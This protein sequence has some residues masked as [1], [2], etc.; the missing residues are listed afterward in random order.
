MGNKAGKAC[1][2]LR[3]DVPVPVLTCA[4]P[5]GAQP[6]QQESLE[7]LNK[8]LATMWPKVDEAIQKIVHDQVT[9]QLQ[10]KLPGPLK[11]THFKKF[12]LGSVTPRLGPIEVVK[13]ETGL[14]LILGMDYES[15]ADIEIS[16]VVATIGIKAIK[17]KGNLVIRMAPFMDDL[18]VVGGLT[19]YFVDPPELD[20]SFTGIGKIGQCPGIA[21][22]IRNEIHAVLG[23]TAVLPNSIAVP[24]GTPEQGVDPCLLKLPMPIAVLRVTALRAVKLTAKDWHLMSKASSDPFVKVHIANDIWQSSVRKRTCDPEWGIEDTHD[25]MVFDRDQ[26][27]FVDVLDMEMLGSTDLIG[28]V[29]P[30]KVIDA[31]ARSEKPLPLVDPKHVSQACGNLEMKF[32]WLKLVPLQKNSESCI[33][34]VKILNL[35]LPPGLGEA[36]G[37]TGTLGSQQLATPVATAQ[38]Q[39][40][41][42]TTAVGQA[43]A[44]V[45][46]RCKAKGLDVDAIAEITGLSKDG[47][48]AA[49]NSEGDASNIASSHSKVV[50]ELDGLLYFPVPRKELETQEL[51]ISAVNAQNKPFAETAINMLDLLASEA[52]RLPGP[53]QLCV[54]KGHGQHVEAQIEVSI[55][56]LQ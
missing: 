51:M 17:F 54:G 23:N 24:I 32:E 21:G 2:A 53:F 42:T 33:V 6:S 25:F 14:K 46:K 9:P 45:A 49:L 18:P 38:P 36:A 16:V 30:M 34:M 27:M 13:T 41:V 1:T 39:K 50:L 4:A 37:I 5:R 8:I 20:L 35:T 12:T 47:V 28:K 15:N 52:L 31:A 10:A 55:F 56:G 11:K 22:L 3:Q 44:D 40:Q 29:G 7:W 48:V 26:Q 43:L 19:V